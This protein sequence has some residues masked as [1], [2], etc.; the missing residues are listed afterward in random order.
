MHGDDLDDDNGAK[1][2]DESPEGG[3][4][5]ACVDGLGAAVAEEV[6]DGIGEVVPWRRGDYGIEE[7]INV[8][9]PGV[10]RLGTGHDERA[11][12]AVGVCRVGGRCLPRRPWERLLS[13][14]HSRRT[15]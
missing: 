3:H 9:I 14:G 1:D 8:E 4:E 10:V 13:C 12:S 2:A 7:A 6:G 15:V 5:V 11:A